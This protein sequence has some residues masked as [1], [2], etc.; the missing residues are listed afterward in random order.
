[1]GLKMQNMN[2]NMEFYSKYGYKI[3]KYRQKIAI[4]RYAFFK[5]LKFYHL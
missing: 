5:S 1:M 3:M 2:K 4:F